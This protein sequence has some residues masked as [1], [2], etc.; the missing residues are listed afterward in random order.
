MYLGID[1][2]NDVDDN[3][4]MV[5]TKNKGNNNNNNDDDSYNRKLK[6]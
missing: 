6:K 4:N 3:V 2:N 5:L 1:Y